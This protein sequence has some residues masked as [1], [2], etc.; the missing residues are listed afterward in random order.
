MKELQ[1]C[2]RGITDPPSGSPFLKRKSLTYFRQAG[3]FLRVFKKGLS[4]YIRLSL[5][6]NLTYLGSS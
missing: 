5:S 3:A 2:P 6:K 1:A 4:A